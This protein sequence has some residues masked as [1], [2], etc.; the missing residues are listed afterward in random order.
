[1]RLRDD[2]ILGSA[3]VSRARIGVAPKQSFPR[4]PPVAKMSQAK[5]VRDREDAF[6]NTR[7]A[8]ATQ[9]T[10]FGE[11]DLPIRRRCVAWPRAR[12]RDSILR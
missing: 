6:A 9:N 5:K 3:R 11:G 7:D 12:I 8:C 4:V 2:L 1:M 10:A